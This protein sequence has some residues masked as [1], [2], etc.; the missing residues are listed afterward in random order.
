MEIT[1][2]SVKK[3]IM[4]LKEKPRDSS[5]TG[6]SK[7]I[8]QLKLGFKFP[9]LSK[10]RMFSAFPSNIHVLAVAPQGGFHEDKGGWSGAAEFFTYND[11]GTC[12][13]GIKNVK[14]SNTAAQLAQEDVTYTINEKATILLPVE[15]NE[16][17]GF[18]YSLKWYDNEFP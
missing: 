2:S 1:N 8:N 7:S 6:F 18:L 15:G 9:S 17:S 16:S 4:S 14:V 11:I 5:Y 3:E 12:S 10:N 13:Y